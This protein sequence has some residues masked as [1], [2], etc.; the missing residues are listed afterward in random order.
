MK[1][2]QHS[3]LK[4][5]ETT[6][7]PKGSTPPRRV[8]FSHELDTQLEMSDTDSEF[9]VDE[10]PKRHTVC[11]A[12]LGSEYDS[13]D[14]VEDG[15]EEVADLKHVKLLNDDDSED[16]KQR[17]K[18]IDLDLLP[19][20]DQLP[21]EPLALPN[22][23]ATLLDEEFTEDIFQNDSDV[24]LDDE[25]DSGEDRTLKK[26]SGA[27]DEQTTSI[28]I[29]DCIREL[30]NEIVDKVCSEIEKAQLVKEETISAVAVEKD[31][32]ES[33]S[34][35]LNVLTSKQ[36][37]ESIDNDK[38]AGESDDSE[39]SDEVPIK[40]QRLTKILDSCLEDKFFTAICSDL[41]QMQMELETASAMV[42]DDVDKS[43]SGNTSP[44]STFIKQGSYDMGSS[45][46]SL[47][48]VLSDVNASRNKSN[49]MKQM[50]DDVSIEGINTD[51]SID[52]Q[53]V[54]EKEYFSHN[55]AMS[56][57]G[58]V[59][60]DAA[61]DFEV[62]NICESPDSSESGYG[63]EPEVCESP[64]KLMEV[65]VQ[66]SSNRFTEYSE[67]DIV[68]ALI[69]AG[70]ITEEESNMETTSSEN[71]HERGEDSSSAGE[72]FSPVMP[73]S[74]QRRK[75]MLMD[76][77]NMSESDDYHEHDD[78]MKTELPFAGFDFVNNTYIVDEDDNGNGQTRGRPL[79]RES[80]SSGNFSGSC[81][82][83]VVKRRDRSKSGNRRLSA[84]HRREA[85][86]CNYNHHY[87]QLAVELELHQNGDNDAEVENINA[88]DDVPPQ[89]P[90]R[91][92]HVYEQV[93]PDG[94]VLRKP[95]D[96]ESLTSSPTS[97][98][99]STSISFTEWSDLD[100]VYERDEE[101]SIVSADG[102]LENT[103]GKQH[104][105]AEDVLKKGLRQRAL[106]SEDT[107]SP[108]P[109][110]PRRTWYYTSSADVRKSLV[111]QSQPDM[112]GNGVFSATYA[113][114][115]KNPRN[116]PISLPDIR[117]TNTNAS[118]D[119]GVATGDEDLLLGSSRPHH[120]HL[121]EEVCISDGEDGDLHTKE[122]PK[123]VLR[124]QLESADKTNT[125]KSEVRK[126]QLLDQDSSE[127]RY[128]CKYNVIDL[129]HPNIFVNIYNFRSSH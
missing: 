92:A 32:T 1:R 49:R 39:G 62:K 125:M 104:L 107:F 11:G 33:I 45:C 59:S 99:S 55:S 47:P 75:L 101:G 115:S 60:D 81:S 36:E 26:E 86:A 72:Q 22:G 12:L 24:F 123:P 58:K 76:S 20:P 27:V 70:L 56:Q 4:S 23:E 117:K 67:I 84:Q 10:P 114:V 128:I 71:D 2:R 53:R 74:S 77:F 52:L 129:V 106:S 5:T 98:I 82:D 29:P 28:L 54:V 126:T 78:V 127:V 46:D 89:K 69:K 100:A 66:E 41:E 65:E 95:P 122:E 73:R 48:D 63:N 30:M 35:A 42:D 85:F 116:K 13:D 44:F 25:D 109:P 19:E 120:H 124:K 79:T 94:V 96:R 91:R 88:S 57:L 97:S 6:K 105:S 21:Y 18:L 9:G 80:T 112:D 83:I 15:Y 17:L 64:C 16:Q 34:A 61:A 50:F 8:T 14:G 111:R 37:E 119:S 3:I 31:N 93:H 118:S 121:Y 68:E 110:K 51:G 43:S 40:E 7:S 113:R 108:T 102:I 103:I 87:E 90:T 38:K